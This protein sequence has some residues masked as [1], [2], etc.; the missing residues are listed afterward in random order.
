MCDRLIDDVLWLMNRGVVEVDPRTGA[1]EH[2][3]ARGGI[4]L[5]ECGGCGKEC[6]QEG[7]H[8]DEKAMTA[9]PLKVRLSGGF[10]CVGY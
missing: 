1:G 5:A 10:P 8:R 2:R 4:R 9:H 7:Q 6:E 3:G